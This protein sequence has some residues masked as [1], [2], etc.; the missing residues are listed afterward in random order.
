MDERLNEPVVPAGE[1]AAPQPEAVPQP[2]AAPPAAQREPA[3]R[4]VGST[5]M[6]LA[7]IAAGLFILCVYFVPGFPA[8]TVLKLAPLVLVALGAEMV[9]R[10]RRGERVRYDLL[11]IFISLILLGA[12]CVAS[13]IPMVAEYYRPGQYDMVRQQ[14][15]QEVNACLDGSQVYRA[16]VYV[17]LNGELGLTDE[18]ARQTARVSCELELYGPFDSTEAF[19]EACRQQAEKL[20]PLDLESLYFSWSN[21]NQ[22][23][24]LWMDPVL[25]PQATAEQLASQVQVETNMTDDEIGVD[26]GTYENA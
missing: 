5:T 15:K 19:A 7:L 21:D 25:S 17:S 24:T 22:T 6:G 16:D 23:M 18:Q 26:E 13:L 3:P 11:S 12:G 1:P 10:S 2:V 9:W 20:Q 4:R 8:I 14:A